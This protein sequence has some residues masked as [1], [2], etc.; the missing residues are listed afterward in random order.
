MQAKAV[1]LPTGLSTDV[2][3]LTE[4]EYEAKEVENPFDKR[5]RERIVNG[6]ITIDNTEYLVIL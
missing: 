3:N 2:N 4:L 1:D 6:N 5:N